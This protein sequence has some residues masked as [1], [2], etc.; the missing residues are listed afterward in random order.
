[1]GKRRLVQSAELVIR[2]SSNANCAGR[3]R[4]S[5]LGG[6]RTAARN[7]KVKMLRSE[8]TYKMKI[9]LRVGEKGLGF[10]Y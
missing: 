2:R 3:R 8:T 6:P 4:I 9:N 1:M 7:I 5:Q 10:E